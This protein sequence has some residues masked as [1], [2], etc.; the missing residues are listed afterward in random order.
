MKIRRILS[1]VSAAAV[2]CAAV[3][4]T[5]SANF[6]PIDSTSSYVSAEGSGN[7]GIFVTAT[8]E[9]DAPE[10]TLAEDFGI[11]LTD[12]GGVYFVVTIPETDSYD[13]D[14]RAFWDGSIGGGVVT[15][16]HSDTDKTTYNWPSQGQFW[17]VVDEDLGIDT[18]DT[19]QSLQMEKVGDYTYKLTCMFDFDDA[20]NSI[21]GDHIVQYRI[22]LQGWDNGMAEYQVTECALLDDGGNEL[23][24][25][26]G[27]GYAI[28]DDA[29]A[30][31][32]VVADDAA[33]TVDAE[34]AATT[35]TDS[36]KGSPDTGVEGVAAV[37]GVAIV[38]A[39][40]VVLSKKRK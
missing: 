19:T 22:F 9:G 12:I 33:A 39:G 36:T 15:S 7:Y 29:A 1:A 11:E 26:T 40:A 18:L 8:G 35:T 37:A 31:E 17:G 28:E 38:A 10:S 14:N 30:E 23:V 13:A 2:A 20:I 24:H 21:E 5:A 3:A 4:T 6:K 25:L 27:D 34:A 32:D 16:L